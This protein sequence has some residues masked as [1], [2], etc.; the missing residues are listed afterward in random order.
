[1][2]NTTGAKTEL[3][4][5]NSTATKPQLKVLLVEDDAADRDLIRR[6]LAKGE[7]EI[8]TAAVETAEDF[9]KQIRAQRPDVVLS[10]YNLGQWKGTEALQIL[11]EEGLDVPLILV[12][13]FLGDATAVEC[14]KLGV[15]DYVLKDRL[16]RLPEAI[17]GAFEEQGLREERRLAVAALASKIEELSRSNRDLEQFAYVAAHDLQEPLRMVASYTQLLASGYRGKLDNDA[18]KYIDYAV[19]GAMRMQTLIQDL[20]IF[21]RLGRAGH[22]GIDT[23]CNAVVDEVLLNLQGMVERSGALVTCGVLPN[24]KA[25]RSQLVQLFQNLIDNAIKF[26]GEAAPVIRIWAETADAMQVFAVAD[27]GIGIAAEHLERIFVLFQRLHTRQEYGG[28][29]VGLAICNRIVEQHGG[30]LSVKS[31]LGSGSTFRFSLPAESGDA[32][33]KIG[34]LHA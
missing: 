21:S 22:A 18:D 6:E 30:K 26:R 1:M 2:M 17:R 10:D 29:G 14:M 34:E 27:N 24:V 7:F 3:A 32:S 33:G 19:D 31:S 11:R 16:A 12:S 28:T 5:E 20:L 4:S 23:D 13:G 8:L 15:A 25:N 9:R